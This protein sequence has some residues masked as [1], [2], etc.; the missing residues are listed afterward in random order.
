MP[1][2]T[3][4]DEREW[5][6]AALQG[7]PGQLGSSLVE[8]PDEPV[9]HSQAS[10]QDGEPRYHQDCCRGVKSVSSGQRLLESYTSRPSVVSWGMG[11][12]ISGVSKLVESN[13][14]AGSFPPSRR[15]MEGE[16]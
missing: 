10:A 5:K 15:L 4:I 1:M 2:G 8:Y 9:G 14:Y 6:E 7:I 13:A 16:G 11:I 12:Q 3:K